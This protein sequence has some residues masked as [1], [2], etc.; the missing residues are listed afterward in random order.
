[1]PQPEYYSIL[2]EARMIK[3]VSIKGKPILGLS[4][5]GKRMGENSDSKVLSEYVCE[6]KWIKTV[7]REQAKRRKKPKLY[8]TTHVRAS[9][10]GQPETVRFIEQE[11]Q[12]E[13]NKLIE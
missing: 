8:T 11:F 13:L 10:E 4:L 9:L 7:P 1:M 3:D 12:V 5:H 2:T 6:V